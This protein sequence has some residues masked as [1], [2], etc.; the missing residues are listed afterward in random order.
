M[1]LSNILMTIFA[2][3]MTANAIALFRYW[4]MLR[5]F[6]IVLNNL[7][8][9]QEQFVDIITEQRRQLHITESGPVVRDGIPSAILDITR[10]RRG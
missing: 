10:P 7:T 1:T 3:T 6:R 8:N 2:L 5:V 9:L 4:Q